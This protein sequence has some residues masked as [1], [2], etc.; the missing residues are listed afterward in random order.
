M[1]GE[2]V[3]PRCRDIERK[4]GYMRPE[5]CA[6]PPSVPSALPSGRW[7]IRD[8]CGVVCAVLTWFLVLYADFVVMFVV[9]LPVRNAVYSVLNATL[10][11][12]L[13]VLALTSHSRAM[14]T[15]PV[16][17][18]DPCDCASKLVYRAMVRTTIRFG[19]KAES[20]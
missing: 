3:S 7:C 14:C 10:F 12:T 6:F 15:D 1:L 19:I 18:S 4:A 9:L 13:A 16:S 5:E 11:N 17:V 20:V 8:V 2:V